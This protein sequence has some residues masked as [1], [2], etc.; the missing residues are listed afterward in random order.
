M[1]LINSANAR[2]MAARS[3]AARRLKRESA[4]QAKNSP[5]AQ[6]LANPLE[7]DTFLRNGITRTRGQIDLVSDLLGKE[8]EASK[9]NHLCAGL[10]KLYEIERI[11][12]NRPAPG[13]LRF[14]E[15][16]K[17]TRQYAPGPEPVVDS[18]PQTH[19][20]NFLGSGPELDP[21]Y[22]PQVAPPPPVTLAPAPVPMAQAIHK[23]PVVAIAQPAKPKVLVFNARGAPEYR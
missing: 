10:A 13:N 6:P 18:T 12:S 14:K 2:E 23:Q 3:A 11:L 22:Q 15:I 5:P 4:L 16:S 21:D 20:H 8:R 1:P 17:R 9:I 19:H 7:A